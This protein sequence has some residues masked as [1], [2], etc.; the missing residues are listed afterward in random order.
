MK[1]NIIQQLPNKTKVDGLAG[2]VKRVFKRT[3]GTK[4]DGTQ[5]SAQQIVV[6]DDTGEITVSVWDRDA[7]TNAEGQPVT[8]TAGHSE[9]HG[10]IGLSVDDNEYQGKVTKRVKASPSAN[11]VIG[12]STS[13]QYDPRAAAASAPAPT[14]EP[15]YT[16][17][18]PTPAPAPAPAHSGHQADPRTEFLRASVACSKR[19]VQI[20]N[21]YM[22][23]LDRAMKVNDWFTARNGEPM[24]EKLFSGMVTTMVIE[25]SRNGFTVNLPDKEPVGNFLKSLAVPEVD[26]FSSSQPEPFPPRSA[27]PPVTPSAPPAATAPADDSDDVPF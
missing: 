5:W 8:I 6:A 14:P 9:K 25:L 19:A 1:I 13:K 23:A 18:A 15:T 24:D 4:A 7:I 12:S 10:A 20:G 21:A 16:P 3:E 27:T 17:P 26:G 2:K 11:I 22:I